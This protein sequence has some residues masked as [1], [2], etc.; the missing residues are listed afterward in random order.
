[1]E[2][3]IVLDT[4]VIFNKWYLEGPSF[5]AIEQLVKVDVCKLVVP[6]IVIAEVKSKYKEEVIAKI[7]R[8]SQLNAVLPP[9]KRIQRIDADE[10]YKS[11]E[12]YLNKKFKELGVLVP[13]HGDISQNDIVSRLFEKRKPF[14][15]KQ[16]T[17]KG[18]RDSLL[19]EVIIKK[20]AC[21]GITTVLITENTHDF[22]E[23]NNE[24]KLHCDLLEDIKNCGMDEGSVCL[25]SSLE[26]WLSE[27]GM[28]YLEV[29]K[30]AEELKDGKYEDFSLLNWFKSERATFTE[31][32]NEDIAGVFAHWHEIDEP[33]VVYLEDPESIG[34]DEVRSLDKETLYLKAE[35]VVGVNIDAFLEQWEY[36]L[37]TSLLPI[38]LSDPNWNEQYA[39]VCLYTIMPISFSATFDIVTKEITSFELDDIEVWGWCKHCRAAIVSDAA[40][41]CWKCQKEL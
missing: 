19:W 33:N 11:Y 16:T 25:F 27:Q 36:D 7:R 39:F 15:K 1:M 29:T 37:E 31:K 28:Q 41:G 22:A 13:S 12:D 2:I 6:E 23:E 4:N 21:K 14:G 18:Y 30:V 5:R 38:V 10:L 24:G 3:Q 17:D 20:V 32:L 34:V 8:V 35:V 9:E 26:R 40:E